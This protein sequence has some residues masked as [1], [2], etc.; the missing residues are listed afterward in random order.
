VALRI[1]VTQTPIV[2][3]KEK[4]MTGKVLKDLKAPGVDTADLQ[5]AIKEL[6]AEVEARKDKDLAMFFEAFEDDVTAAG[7]TVEEALKK[8]G[9]V[10]AT[11]TKSR[12]RTTS[13]AVQKYADPKNPENTWSGGSGRKP[14][15]MYVDGDRDKGFRPDL[16]GSDGK[17]DTKKLTEL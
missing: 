1:R 2:D 7:Y 15:W 10:K 16:V 13:K 4:N 17:I 12:S 8:H 3:Q 6:Q 11:A 14:E 5:S 9:Y